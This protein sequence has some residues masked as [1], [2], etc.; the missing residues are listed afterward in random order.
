MQ[1]FNYEFA[2]V[3]TSKYMNVNSI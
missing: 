2:D 1:A 3:V